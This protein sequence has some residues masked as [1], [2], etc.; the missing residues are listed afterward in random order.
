MALSKGKIQNTLVLLS[1]L[2]TEANS[3]IRMICLLKSKYG[4]GTFGPIKK[5]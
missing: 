2:K 1:I 4:D 3:N 5:F